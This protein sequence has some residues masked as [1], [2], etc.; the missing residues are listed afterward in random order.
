MA[1]IPSFSHTQMQIIAGSK[2]LRWILWAREIKEI[3]SA[4]KA[5]LFLQQYLY[6]TIA[7]VMRHPAHLYRKGHCSRVSFH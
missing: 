7:V 2:C 3:M 5:F 6:A 1:A 4:L